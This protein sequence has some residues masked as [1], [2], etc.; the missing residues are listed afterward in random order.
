MYST[1]PLSCIEPPSD[2]VDVDVAA[3]VCGG[4]AGVSGGGPVGGVGVGAEGC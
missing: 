3:A 2:V 4:G 1:L